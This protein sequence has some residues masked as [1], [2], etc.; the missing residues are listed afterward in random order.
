MYPVAKFGSLFQLV[1]NSAHTLNLR[2]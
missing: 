2:V 1:V